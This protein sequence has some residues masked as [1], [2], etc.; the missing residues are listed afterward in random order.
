MSL[1]VESKSTPS[2]SD[3]A[4]PQFPELKNDI[5]L[6]AAKGKRHVYPT[7][8]HY[9]YPPA[10]ALSVV[11]LFFFF[12][13]FFFSPSSLPF[14]PSPSL[15]LK[16][17]RAPVWIHRQAGRYL[18]EFREV[19]K[20]SD[21][22]TICRT[23]SLACEI[24]LQPLRR[25]PLDAAII[26]SDILVIPQAL[27]LEV[28]MQPG[29]GP[30]LPQ[31]LLDP[32]DMAARLVK[33]DEFDVDATLGYVFE[34]ITLTRTK[35]EGKVPLIGFSG[36]PWTLMAYMVQGQGAKTYHKAKAWLY[37][38]PEASHEL[39]QRTTDAIVV[40]LVGQVAAG[41]QM[42]EV[43]DSWAGDLTPEAFTTFCLPYLKQ[44][45]T[46]VKK[47]LREQKLEEV[48]M[49]VFPRGAHYA[50]EALADTDY[51]VISLDWTLD[52]AEA[53]KRVQGK[54]ALQGNLDSSVFFASKD[55]IERE[56]C[57]MIDQFGPQSFIANLG[58]GML[59]S[60]D[61]SAVATFVETVHSHSEKLNK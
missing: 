31:P 10:L 53:R 21:F 3:S 26:F 40:Y 45:A 23:P 12:F 56:T 43:F 44:I 46:R 1:P 24:T 42:L 51:D 58:H 14:P 11:S 57:H 33:P 9:I 59:P 49:T 29:V 32:D 48:P 28:L 20:T 8:P 22:F 5:I 39:L 41:A 34:A 54:V 38:Y 7:T 17:S 35:L 61:P 25:F 30:V 60:H 52:P 18:P 55:V 4:A 50:L 36:A 13:F 15:G 37:R 6:R 2:E 16:T 47:S 27:G 19:R